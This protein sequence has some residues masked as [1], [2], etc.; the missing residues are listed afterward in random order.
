VAGAQPTFAADADADVLKQAADDNAF[1]TQLS[2]VFSENNG[3]DPVSVLVGADAA[4]LAKDYSAVSMAVGQHDAGAATTAFGALA[5][6]LRQLTTDQVA[7]D[8]ACGIP[9]IVSS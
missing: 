3:S 4:K 8:A 9:T 6:D 5:D 2:L 1:Y 7:F